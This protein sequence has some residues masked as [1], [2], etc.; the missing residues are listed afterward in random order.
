MVIYQPINGYCYNSDT[1]FLYSFICKCL[2]K[3]KNIQGELL[4]IGSGS[5]VL[6]FLLVKNYS[7]LVLNQIEIQKEFQFLS[8][9]NSQINKISTSLYC[10]DFLTINFDKEF[11][12][13][14]SNPPFY[15]KNVIKSENES[16][17]IA[18]YNDKLPLNELIKK[19][20]QILKSDGKLFFCYDSKQLVEIFSSLK[21][22]KFNI[23]SIQFVHPKSNKDASLV[24]VYAKKDSKSLLKIFKPLIVFEENGKFTQEVEH[25]YKNISL[26]SIKAQYSE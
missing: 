12:I 3:Y 24:L 16:L 11:D 21:E 6:G 19:A 26:N 2:E 10:E 22:Y 17:S 20:S 13:C 5:G 4:D 7:K 25:I 14:V 15:H 1:H 9:K 23:E 18:R 8:N